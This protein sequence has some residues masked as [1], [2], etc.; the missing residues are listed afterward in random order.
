M[1]TL[2]YAYELTLGVLELIGRKGNR[3]GDERKPFTVYLQPVR[4]RH[5]DV[6]FSCTVGFPIFLNITILEFDHESCG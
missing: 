1:T 3:N 4:K 5:M 6:Y 2:Y